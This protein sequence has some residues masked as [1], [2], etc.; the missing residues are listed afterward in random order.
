MRLKVK[1]VICKSDI[2][3]EHLGELLWH[4][5]SAVTPQAVAKLVVVASCYCILLPF[6]AEQ[7][8][9]PRGYHSIRQSVFRLVIMEFLLF[10]K[11]YP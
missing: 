6:A 1:A 8:S 2:Y 4:D 3:C 9:S 11:I 5:L 7:L 10:W